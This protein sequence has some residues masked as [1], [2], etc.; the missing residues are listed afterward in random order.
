[1]W[2]EVGAYDP[3]EKE[4]ITGRINR[5]KASMAKRGI[6]FAVILQTVDL[7]YLTGTAQ[8]G[9]LVIALGHDPLLFIEKSVTRARAETPLDIIPIKNNREVRQTLEEKK[10]LRGKGGME[11]DVVPVKVYEQFKNVLGFDGFTDISPLVRGLRMVKS[12]YELEQMRKAEHIFSHVYERGKEVIREGVAEVEI[13]AHLVAEGR[14]HGYQGRL[15]MRGLNHEMLNMCVFAGVTSGLP[16]GADVPISGAGVTPAVPQGSSFLRVKQ[17]IPVIVDYGSGYNGY[18]TDESRVYVAGELKDIFRRPYETARQ[19]IEEAAGFGKAG[20]STTELFERADGLVRRAG[21]E[22]NFMG[23]GEGQV[24]FIGHGLGLEINEMPVIT[25]KHRWDLEENM[26]FAYEPKFIFP[27]L[28]AIG[29]E[30]VFLVRKDRLE[31][32]SDVPLDIVYV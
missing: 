23:F 25:A 31:A 18:I 20:V 24:S 5:L 22:K 15:R 30:V 3:V 26:T 9:L 17:G 7:Y 13:D 4:E 21:L 10:I 6:D 29:L 28:G 12:R 19:I 32:L 11:L 8:K 16:S 27:G 1:M 14:R 2:R